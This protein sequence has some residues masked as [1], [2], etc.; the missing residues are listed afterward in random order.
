MI[1]PTVGRVVH[2]YPGDGSGP[3][4]ALISAV[5]GVGCINI[6]AFKKNGNPLLD[7]P[8]SVRLLQDDEPVPESGA[9]CQWM[10]YQV[11]KATGSESGE[12]QA[13]VQLI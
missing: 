5:W 1:E 2:F 11:K 4:V 7:A 10:P 6:A 13:G 3:L 12:V 8:T 9:Y